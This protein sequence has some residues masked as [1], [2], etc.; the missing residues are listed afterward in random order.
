M[1][2]RKKICSE[3]NLEFQPTGN[4]QLACCDCKSIREIRLKRERREKDPSIKIRCAEYQR[5]K[6]NDPKNMEKERKLERKRYWKNPEKF[7]NK[8]SQYQKQRRET[9]PEFVEKHRIQSKE[10]REKYGKEL[11]AKRKEQYHS[12]PIERQ[13]R[14]DFA[15]QYHRNNRDKRLE[16]Q[17]KYYE[18]NYERFAAK[19]LIQHSGRE[20]DKETI[21]Q[22]F[23]RD[24]YTCQYC[25]K[26]GGKLSIDH[27]TPVSHNGDN[28]EDNLC[29]SCRNCNSSKGKKSLLDFLFFL[30]EIAEQSC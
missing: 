20:I 23:E 25:Y 16:Y 19:N 7:R 28:N 17:H 21:K 8:S 26:Y 5:K 24:N 4:K 30:S 2:I 22:V 10:Y 12:D 15:K 13:K 9:D 3:C 14:I 18:Q 27:I 11:D 6:R 1:K 29:V